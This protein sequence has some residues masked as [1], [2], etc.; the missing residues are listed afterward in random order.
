MPN[1][2]HVHPL[3]DP[4]F[5]FR[6]DGSSISVVRISAKELGL[7]RNATTLEIF[8]AAQKVNLLLCPAEVVLQ[9][10]MQHT[11]LL[12]SDEETIFAMEPVL[13]LDGDPFVFSLRFNEHHCDLFPRLCTPNTFWSYAAYWIFV[14]GR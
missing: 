10:W 1:I 11:Y 12:R 14:R 13:D 3:H 8:T 6:L 2:Y 5:H 7:R 4:P 9:F